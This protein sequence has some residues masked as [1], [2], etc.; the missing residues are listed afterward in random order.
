MLGVPELQE[1]FLRGRQETSATTVE[2]RDGRLWAG[3]LEDESR[4][5]Q[6]M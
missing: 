1:V 5:G 3:H 6:S 4:S 2:L